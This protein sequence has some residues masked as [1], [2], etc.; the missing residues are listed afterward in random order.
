MVLILVTVYFDDFERGL[1]LVFTRP[2][3]SDRSEVT[4]VDEGD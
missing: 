2:S 4:L 3:L 1:K